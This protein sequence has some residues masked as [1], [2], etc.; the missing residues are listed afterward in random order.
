MK[1]LILA[2]ILLPLPLLV[3]TFPSQERGFQAEKAFHVGEPGMSLTH[4]I[5]PDFR[6]PSTGT[7][8]STSKGTT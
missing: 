6:M 3:D 1:K 5:P 8:T 2:L 4:L 7:S